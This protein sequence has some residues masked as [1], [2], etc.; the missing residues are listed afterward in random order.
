M[1]LNKICFEL[2]EAFQP[3][4]QSRVHCGIHLWTKAKNIPAAYCKENPV[5]LYL[6]YAFGQSFPNLVGLCLSMCKSGLSCPPSQPPYFS[7]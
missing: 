4:S 5:G 1:I 2:W 6:I 3:E 7:H